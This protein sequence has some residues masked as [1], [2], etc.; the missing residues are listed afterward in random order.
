MGKLSVRGDDD[1]EFPL[2]RQVT[3]QTIRVPMGFP[4]PVPGM[5]LHMVAA[6]AAAGR[7]PGGAGGGTTT[8]TT[9]N[10][11]HSNYSTLPRMRPVNG[12]YEFVERVAPEGAAA[13]V[14][15]MDQ[16]SVPVMPSAA[17]AIVP[18]QT[19][20]PQPQP[21]Q[22]PPQVVGGAANATASNVF[23]AMNV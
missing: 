3:Q 13:S 9:T 5:Q 20:P 21:Q 16:K 4:L 1:F 7:G 8:T 17:G 15:N 14:Q 10:E 12:N 2:L 18:I 19:G 6:A 23:Y 11:M 22:Q